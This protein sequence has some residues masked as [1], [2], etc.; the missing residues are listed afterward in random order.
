M[1]A[2]FF[3]LS[4]LPFN[5]TPDP[6]FF[7]ATADHEEA[8]ASMVYA[9]GQRKGFMLLTG[10]AGTGKTLLTKMVLQHFPTGI[11]AATINH[12]VQSAND[13][14]AAVA[15]GFGVPVP[16][17]ADN[18]SYVRVLYDFLLAKY[19]H[20]T[21]VVLM[22]D[23]AQT[24]PL[25][26]FEQLRT[27]GN[28]ED[29]N[30]KLLQTMILG[31]PELRPQFQTPGLRQLRQ[32][33]F[34]AF[35][36]S[37]LTPEQCQGYIQHRLEAAG[38]EENDLFEDSAL[39]M[40]YRYSQ[41]VPRLINTVCDNAM[42]SAYAADRSSID[43]TIIESVVSQML[44]IDQRRV[45]RP[46]SSTAG[47]APAA[48][49]VPVPG[50]S[51]DMG[52]YPPP[53]APTPVTC[54]LAHGAAQAFQTPPPR[55]NHQEADGRLERFDSEFD[56]LISRIERLERRA[57]AQRDRRITRPTERRLAGLLRKTHERLVR[58]RDD[59]RAQIGSLNSQTDHKLSNALETTE[60][61]VR[62]V[63]R[64]AEHR[65]VDVVRH[66]D[67]RL[68]GMV[69]KTEDLWRNMPGLRESSIRRDEQLR[70]LTSIV[71]RIVDTPHKPDE[72]V[73]LRTHLEASTTDASVNPPE[74]RGSESLTASVAATSE[75]VTDL[76]HQARAS[77]DDLRMLLADA[78]KQEPPTSAPHSS[79]GTPRLRSPVA[80]LVEEVHGLSEMVDQA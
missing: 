5:N 65:L 62:D 79:A 43:G 54:A 51:L 55:V 64:S 27:L 30:A 73:S 24:L 41:G 11:C 8:L 68:A 28:L 80:E 49:Q 10:E 26:G 72:S 4:E 56:A 71:Q 13:L 67:A 46:V 33:I 60:D 3:G 23:E 52:A 20:G 9:I 18:T 2:E 35:H 50:G 63:L 34:R 42:L 77:M 6:R 38:A 17:N 16:G 31:Q 74:D 12:A 14:L 57:S 48:P 22:I 36:L 66:T 19:A 21:P 59:T 29:D 53:A 61:R 58:V 15:N 70:R 45:P 7:Y 40:I 69:G 47:I 37:A 44:T 25:E 76:V 39:E 1:Y 32:R 75:Q 78:T